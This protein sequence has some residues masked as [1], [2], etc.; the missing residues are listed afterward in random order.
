MFPERDRQGRWD[1]S[2]YTILH[3]AKDRVK[4]ES[5]W[6]VDENSLIFKVLQGSIFML[7]ISLR[8]LCSQDRS[9]SQHFDF[10][11]SQ[12]GRPEG[13]PSVSNMVDIEEVLGTVT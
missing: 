8:A 5:Q 2:T 7:N 13:G 11:P 10:C 4:T 12:G 3:P 1:R 6:M 9:Y